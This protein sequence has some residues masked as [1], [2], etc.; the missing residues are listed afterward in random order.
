MLIRPWHPF[1]QVDVFASQSVIDYGD[2]AVTPGNAER[3]V[4]QIAEA[5]EGVLAAGV[6]P[7]VLG[8]DHSIV[9]GE[10]RAHASAFGPVAVVLFDAHAD[11]WDQYYG[12][13]YFH[14]TPFLR[15]VE[16]GLIDPARSI[17]AGMRGPVYSG[18]DLAAVERMGFEVIPCDELRRLEP[19]EYMRRV[20]DRIGDAVPYLSFDIDVIDP[21]FA[22]ATGT[23]EI[24]GLLPHEALAFLRALAG[25][26][27]VGFDIVE[28][29][30]AYDSHA[31]STALVAAS[32]GYELLALR[33]MASDHGQAVERAK[34][35]D[36]GRGARRI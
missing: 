23:P 3:T 20:R 14:G 32:I 35:S 24:A 19:S 17:M 25:I 18:D 1:H 28:V 33:A 12:E 5:I 9:L 13:R 31:Q 16:E 29:S 11:C 10:L 6:T 15:A 30:P 2:L 21:A 7:L 34:L 8:G 26:A 4:R 27:F 22:P 36:D